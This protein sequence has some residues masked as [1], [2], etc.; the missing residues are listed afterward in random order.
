MH[1]SNTQQAHALP[2]PMHDALLQAQALLR[3]FVHLLPAL[4]AAA[5][6][7]SPEWAVLPDAA[8][9]PQ[10]DPASR[11]PRHSLSGI[12]WQGDGRVAF[13]GKLMASGIYQYPYV[14]C[15]DA[16]C[17]KTAGNAHSSLR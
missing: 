1:C 8:D 7:N 9:E 3:L 15:T 2:S 17:E 5:L 10:A 14:L 13:P 12:S 4:R 11:G 16:E 6:S